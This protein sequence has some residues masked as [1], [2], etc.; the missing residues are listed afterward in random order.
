MTKDETLRLATASAILETAKSPKTVKLT[1]KIDVDGIGILQ[2][3]M[4]HDALHTLFDIGRKLPKSSYENIRRNWLRLQS[5]D[6]F[7][8]MD[9][10]DGNLFNSFETPYNAFL[11][12]MIVLADFDLMV[13]D[14]P[15]KEPVKAKRRKKNREAVPKKSCMQWIG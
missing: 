5:M 7:M 4:Q 2:S 1:T 3:E 13:S 12:Y 8:Y 6:H 11:K 9:T 10:T 14:V 15:K